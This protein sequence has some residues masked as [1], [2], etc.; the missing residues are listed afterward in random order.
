MA[1][2]KF[3]NSQGQW[4]EI[5]AA[6]LDVARSINGVPFDGTQDITIPVGVGSQEYNDLTNKPQI[7]G[8]EL[9][10]N[11]TSSDLNIVSKEPT[12]PTNTESLWIVETDIEHPVTETAYESALNAGYVGTKQEFDGDL[13]KISNGDLATGNTILPTVKDVAD[14][15]DRLL[16]D[17]TVPSDTTSITFDRDKNG[18]LFSDLNIKSYVIEYFASNTSGSQSAIYLRVND[19]STATY[20]ASQNVAAGFFLR[21]GA[22]SLCYARLSIVKNILTFFSISNSSTSTIDDNTMSATPPNQG[23]NRTINKIN[24]INIFGISNTLKAGS[25]FIIYRND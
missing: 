9:S 25:N 24:S 12:T 2:A 17:F 8:I 20:K 18:V 23:L 21:I 1:T 6:K 15:I 19:V 11:K 7:N 5:G 4:E 3:K 22:E 10:G 13:A 14:R 16:V